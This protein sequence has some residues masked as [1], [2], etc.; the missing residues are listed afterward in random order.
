MVRKKDD[1][2]HLI[3]IDETES[4][5]LYLKQ[6]LTDTSVEEFT[7]IVADFQTKGR[8][9]MGNSWHSENGQ[10]LLFSLL[11]F[12]DKVAANEQF[13]ISQI[14]SIALVEVLLEYISD[15]SIKWPNDIYYGDKKIAGILIENNLIG[16]TIESSIIGVGLNVNQSSFPQYLENPSSLNIITSKIFDIDVILSK[17]MHNFMSLYEN[18]R[19]ESRLNIEHTYMKLLYRRN[20]Y[21]WYADDKGLFKAKIEKV[22][23]TGHLW[24]NVENEFVPRVY[25]FKEV[26]FIIDNNRNNKK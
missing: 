11:I 20:G 14:V 24:L 6:Q 4:T 19:N 1:I 23:S 9:Q 5:N 25:A 18:L 3:R 7:V 2:W 21:H 22:A 10:N 15:V 13:V 17:F 16:K 26:R 8:G 12:P